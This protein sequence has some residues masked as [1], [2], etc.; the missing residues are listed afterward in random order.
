MKKILIIV[1]SMVLCTILLIGCSD[2]STNENKKQ[3]EN[4]EVK[5]IMPDGLPAVGMAKIVKEKPEIKDGYNIDYNIEK[6]PDTLSTAV[7]KQEADIAIVPSNMAA[8]AY[9]KTGNYKIAGTT[10]MGSF[11]LVSTEDIDNFKDLEGMEVGNTGKG[12]TPDITTQYILKENDINNNNVNFNY[13]SS[14]SELVPMLA[15]G[16]LNT[17]IVPEPAL[18]AL[19][20]KKPEMKII[21]SLN[22]EY[23]S[24]TKSKIGYPQATI[25]VK[26]DFYNDNKEFVSKFL[27]KVDESVK[28]ANSNPEEVGNYAQ[29][30]GVSTEKGIVSKSIK[31]ANLKFINISDSKEEYK[32]YYNTLYEFDIKTV[33][34]SL[35]DDK[36]FLER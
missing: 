24:I 16:K 25:I 22:E 20:T 6:T 23:K 31:N 21:K 10:G 18:S 19:T 27:N 12:L 2:T 33:G 14:A 32:N 1:I 34:G 28:F 15:T 29:D 35:P 26:S 8:I 9:N 4:I 30:I 5:V 17:A 3:S 7:M 36:I 11:Y 13:T